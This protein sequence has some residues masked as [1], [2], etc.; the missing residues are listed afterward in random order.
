MKLKI[1]NKKILKFDT[2][3][4]NYDVIRLLNKE[5]RHAHAGETTDV[6][7]IRFTHDGDTL[8]SFSELDYRKLKKLVSELIYLSV[9]VANWLASYDSTS[10]L[11]ELLNE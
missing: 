9:D 6:C 2:R 3:R 1:K 7:I 11:M 4:K 5:L 10:S 8:A